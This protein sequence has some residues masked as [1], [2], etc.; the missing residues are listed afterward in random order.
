MHVHRTIFILPSSAWWKAQFG[1][2]RFGEW[3]M[4]IEAFGAAHSPGDT[5]IKSDDVSDG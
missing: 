4:G 2:Q 5:E 1:G 3:N